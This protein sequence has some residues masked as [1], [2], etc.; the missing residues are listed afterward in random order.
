MIYAQFYLKKGKK[1]Q[2]MSYHAA[3]YLTTSISDGDE[4]I[5]G[6]EKQKQRYPGSNSAQI[7][8]GPSFPLPGVS[9]SAQHFLKS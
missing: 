6:L 3:A 5:Y 4:R 2:K 9:K 1:T 7:F 8:H